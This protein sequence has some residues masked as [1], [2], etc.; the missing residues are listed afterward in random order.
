MGEDGAGTGQLFEKAIAIALSRHKECGTSPPKSIFPPTF[1]NVKSLVHYFEGSTAQ[2]L[3]KL[4]DQKGGSW[5]RGGKTEQKKH[6]SGW[7]LCLNGVKLSTQ[8]GNGG[9]LPMRGGVLRAS[10]LPTLLQKKKQARC[11][12]L[13][14]HPRAH[15]PV[16]L[17]GV[18]LDEGGRLQLLQLLLGKLRA[19]PEMDGLAA[20]GWDTRAAAAAASWAT[21]IGLWS[22]S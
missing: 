12:A 2:D 17:R 7:R 5:I 21:A 13:H 6:T 22:R 4:R 8:Y 20:H 10:L 9:E 3:V 18:H 11:G 16:S 14:G 19:S 15:P 1:L